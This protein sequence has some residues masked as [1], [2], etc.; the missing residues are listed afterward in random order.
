VEGGGKL[1]VLALQVEDLVLEIPY[2]TTQLPRLLD[3]S[4]V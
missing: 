3:D 1:V 4:V 2:A